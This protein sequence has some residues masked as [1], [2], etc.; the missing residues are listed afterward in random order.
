M[1]TLLLFSAAT[2]LVCGSLSVD[3]LSADIDQLLLKDYKNQP[4]LGDK[5]MFVESV[6]DS[7]TEQSGPSSSILLE[8]HMMETECSW[9]EAAFSDRCTVHSQSTRKSCKLHLEVD[10]R[11]RRRINKITCSSLGSPAETNDNS[12][13]DPFFTSSTGESFYDPEITVSASNRLFGNFMDRFGREYKNAAEYKHRR[14]VFV[15]NLYHAR[16]FQRNEL[17]TAKYGVTKFSDITEAEWRRDYLGLNTDLPRVVPDG[18]FRQTADIPDVTNMP[19]NFDWREKGA[20]S[21]VKNQGQCGS[22]WAFSVTGNV[23]GQYKIHHGKLL[24][25]SE[26]ELIDCD[27]VDHG[28]EGGLPDQAYKFI[29]TIGGI[30]TEKNYPYE[31]KDDACRYNESFPHVRVTGSLDLPKNESAIQAWLYKNGPVSVGVNANPLQF[32]RGGIID[33]W[34]I[35]CRESGIDHGVLLVGYGV[36]RY[37]IV[38]KEKR[39]WIV[40][41]S[42]GDSWGEQGYFR[43]ILGSNECGVEAMASS[44]ILP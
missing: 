14:A 5:S 3:Q 2:Q 13:D 1:W 10:I 35:L 30:T 42:W 40:K 29:E 12:L 41:N 23:E 22:C 15:E 44:A 9:E 6:L 37:N 36:H 32:Y 24:S 17:G 4:V 7:L 28:C 8:A 25:L 21:P 39:Y 33:V 27:S 19:P 34:S 18:R 43:L 26:Q 31:A 38:H 20:V 11:G 16:Q